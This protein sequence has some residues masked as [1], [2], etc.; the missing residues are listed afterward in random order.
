[1]E[2]LGGNKMEWAGK[3]D[4]YEKCFYS[5]KFALVNAKVKDDQVRYIFLSSA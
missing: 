1:M 2:K 4:V 5:Y 3:A